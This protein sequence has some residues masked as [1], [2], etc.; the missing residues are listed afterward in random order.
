M[1]KTSAR[2]S[3]MVLVGQAIPH[4]HPSILGKLLGQLLGEAAVLDAVVEAAEHTGGILHRFLV[5]DLRALRAEVGHV[6][7]LIV[8]GHLE[9]AARAG[10]ALLE[11]QRDLLAHQVL[12]LGAVP[13]GRLQ[14]FR[15]GQ[16]VANL[17]RRKVHQ[18]EEIAVSK[19]T[20]HGVALLSFSTQ[21]SIGSAIPRWT[22]PCCA[23]ALALSGGA[24]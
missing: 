23:V 9:G 16:K 2:M 20:R 7:A 4:R 21:L 12:C 19:F 15:H 5:S 6:R 17:V 10:R 14:V 1:V 18:V 22:N 3:G 8:G 24:T 11:Y 13:L